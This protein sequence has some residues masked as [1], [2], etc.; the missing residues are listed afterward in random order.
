MQ[1]VPLDDLTGMMRVKV[2]ARQRHYT[3]NI[4]PRQTGHHEYI[5]HGLHVLNGR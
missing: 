2:T 4:R 5:V 1:P 3:G